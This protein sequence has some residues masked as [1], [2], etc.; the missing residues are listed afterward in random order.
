A[1]VLADLLSDVNPTAHYPGSKL[2]T[3]LK[4]MGVA[5]T[6]MGDIQGT[7]DGC[8]VVSR[9]DSARG[10]YKKFVLKNNQL[11]G[12]IVLGEAD[13][14]GRFTRFFKEEQTIDESALDLLQ[15]PGEGGDVG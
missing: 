7:D 4:V 1:R 9:L 13:P 10:T 8:E 5:L 6:S 14:L 3:T 12:A 2:A 15:D 11:V